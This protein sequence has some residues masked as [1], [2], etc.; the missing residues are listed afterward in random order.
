M[1]WLLQR[2]KHVRHYIK[3]QASPSP[4]C[5]YPC[6]V[7]LQLIRGMSLGKSLLVTAKFADLGTKWIKAPNWQDMD[8]LLLA[9]YIFMPRWAEPRVLR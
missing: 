6:I 5:T 3:P 9:F 8:S 4:T 1:C 2:H 7:A